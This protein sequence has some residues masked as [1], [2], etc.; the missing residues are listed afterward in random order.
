MVTVK[1]FFVVSVA[2]NNERLLYFMDVQVAGASGRFPFQP[3]PHSPPVCAKK[4]LTVSQMLENNLQT[5]HRFRILIAGRN[6]KMKNFL[7]YFFFISKIL[8]I[9]VAKIF[10]NRFLTILK[11]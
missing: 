4:W 2:K 5:C 7:Q 1:I 11:K 6:V 9:F 3:F 8:L 10:I